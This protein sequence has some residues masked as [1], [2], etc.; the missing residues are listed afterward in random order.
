MYAHSRLVTSVL[1]SGL[2]PITSDKAGL[3]V[4]GFMKAG[5]GFRA[6]LVA[7][8]AMCLLSRRGKLLAHIVTPNRLQAA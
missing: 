5:L 6:D 1:G 8:L 3:G 2:A 4:I 7:R